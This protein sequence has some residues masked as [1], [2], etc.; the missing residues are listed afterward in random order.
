MTYFR[1]KV[2]NDK[3]VGLPEEISKEDIMKVLQEHWNNPD[4]LLNGGQRIN[5]NGYLYWKEE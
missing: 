1:L 5:V 2:W 4:I 3:V